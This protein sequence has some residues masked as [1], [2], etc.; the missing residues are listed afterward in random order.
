VLLAEV[1][2][3]VASLGEDGTSGDHHSTES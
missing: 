3:I 2:R 1:R